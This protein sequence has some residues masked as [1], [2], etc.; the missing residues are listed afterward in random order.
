MDVK[1]RGVALEEFRAPTRKPK[2][3]VVSLKAGG[4]GLNVSPI[5]GQLS[6]QQLTMH[7]NLADDGQ[8][9]I[10][11]TAAS[12]LHALYLLTHPKMD[13]WWNAATENQGKL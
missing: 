8:S 7:A 10:Y 4:V 11:G 5:G 13:C 6:L 9:C 12:L 2:V 3:L 1:K